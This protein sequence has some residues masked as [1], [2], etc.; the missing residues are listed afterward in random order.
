MDGTIDIA[1]V[2]LTHPDRVLWPAQGL[3]KRDLADH[4]AG[5]AGRLL[6]HVAGRPLTLLRCPRGIG[7]RCF[8]QRHMGP[9][10][11]P[12]IRRVAIRQRNGRT[13]DHPVVEDV[14]G[15]LAL[16]Q[17]GVLEIHPWAARAADLDRADR[18]VFDLD[19]GEG[20]SW[21]VTL[22]GAREIR[23]RLAARGLAGF[24]KTSGGKGLHV[25]V[26][27]APAVPWDRAKG[28]VRDV[29]AA[30]AGERPDRYTT[31]PARAERAGRIFIDYLRNERGASTVAPWS[32]RARA[33]AP[34]SMP[35][36]WDV[37]A[38][39]SSPD[40]FSLATFVRS[41]APPDPWPDFVTI[42]QALPG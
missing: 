7:A 40:R 19:P 6:P 33:G 38:A 8:V 13:E 16:V 42:R 25:V 39:R 26:P 31:A 22:R 36:S 18:L 32:P 5:V 9:G 41:G 23:D 3:S 21:A 17:S 12:E 35:L 34:V 29:A 28:F 37:T 1:G 2:A 27:V 14:Q 10:F 15:L 4:F 24:L 20:V 30:M 11:G